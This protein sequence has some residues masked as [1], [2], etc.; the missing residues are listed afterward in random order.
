MGKTNPLKKIVDELMAQEQTTHEYHFFSG[1]ESLKLEREALHKH[2]IR[3]I[4]SR[5][6]YS[7]NKRVFLLGGAPANG[8]SSLIRSGFLPHPQN[9]LKVDV[10]EIKLMLPEYRYMIETKEPL[11]AAIVHEESANI[12]HELRQTALERGYD[13]IWDG[14]A[15]ESLEHRMEVAAAFKGYGHYSRVDYVSLD[16][17]LSLELAEARYQK[18]GRRVPENYIKEKNRDIAELVPE[19]IRNQVFDELYLWDTNIRNQPRLILSQI[20]G[21]LE[22]VDETLYN[23]FKMKSHVKGIIQNEGRLNQRRKKYHRL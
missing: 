13:L 2:I 10:D 3:D 4:L 12:G 7:Q 15:D 9:A 8:K 11:A 14:T 23:N 18:T 19:L 22:M 17:S 20:N 21:K 5:Q 6:S 1:N 16:T